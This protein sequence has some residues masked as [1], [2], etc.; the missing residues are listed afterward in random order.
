VGSNLVPETSVLALEVDVLL[1]KQSVDGL[2]LNFHHLI[3]DILDF[4]SELDQKD[5]DAVD[6]ELA[7]FVRALH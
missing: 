2:L 7:R 5:V 6:K 3:S 4:F 1:G